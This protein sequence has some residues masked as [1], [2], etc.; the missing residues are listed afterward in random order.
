M[1]SESRRRRRLGGIACFL[2]GI[3]LLAAAAPA[4]WADASYPIWAYAPEPPEPPPP[5]PVPPPNGYLNG[6]CG[7]AVDASGT[8]YLADHYHRV[9]DLL[10]PAHAYAGQISGLEA[11]DGPCGLGLGSGGQLYVNAY[12]RSVREYGPAPGPVLS[13]AGADSAH[14]TG[15]AVDPASGRVYVNDRTYVG[16]YDAA[17][18]PVEEGGQPLRLGVGSLQDGYGL[19]VSAYPG[20][21]GYVYVPDAASNTVKVYDPAAPDKSQPVETIA[22]PPGG[23]SSLRDAAVAV[24]RVSGEVYVVD[25]LQPGATE[26]PHA[27][28]EAFEAG[29]AYAGHLKFEVIDGAPSG[30][31]V[32][33]SAGATQGRV[34]VTSGNTEPGGVY[35]YPPGAVTTALPLPGPIPPPPPAGTSLFTTTAIGGAAEAGEGILCEGDA[36]QVLPPEPVDPTLTTLLEGPGNP[37]IHYHQYK[38]RKA[39]KHRHRKGAR[40]HKRA[41]RALPTAGA[42]SA[43]LGPALIAAS[44]SPAGVSSSSPSASAVGTPG[45]PR[46]A[47]APA[48]PG[49]EAHARADGGEAATFA[50]SHPYALRIG[51][52]LDQG[53]GESDLSNLRLELPPGLLFDPPAAGF[54][55]EAQLAS[56]RSSPFEASASGER[57]PDRS[58]VGTIEVQSGGHEARSFGLFEL[59][60]APGTAAR[61]AAAPFGT[62]L[63]FDAHLGEGEEGGAHLALQAT[64]VPQSLALHSLALNLWGTPW[65]A[66]HNPQRGNC[67]D[68]VE[69]SFGWCKA[70]VG[71][72]VQTDNSPLALLTLPTECGGPLAFTAQAEA[73]GGGAFSGEATNRGA[74]GQPALLERCETLNFEPR[75]NGVFSVRKASSAT[76]FAFRLTNED[77]GLVNPRLRAD[78][79][80]RVAVVH[81]PEGV[82]LNPSLGAGLEVC[83]P[84]QVAA[85]SPT[86]APGSGCPSGSKIGDFSL[87]FPFY[88]GLLDGAIYLAEPYHNPYGSL[89]AV[90][91]VAKSAGRGLLVRASGKLIPDPADGTITATFEH[92]PQLPYT[93]LEVNFRS[94]QRAPLVSPP[95]CGPAVARIELLPWAQGAPTRLEET[96]SPIE[97][98]IEDGPC[99]TAGAPPFAPGAVAGGVNSNIG[100]YTP[101][102][103]HIRRRDTEQEITSYSLVLPKG[104]TGKLAGIPFCPDAAIEAARH[105]SGVA[106]TASPSCPAASQVGRTVTGYGVGSALTYSPGRIYLAGPYHGAPLSL[107]TIDAATIGPFDLGTIVIRS[108]FDL[109][110]RTAQLQIDSRASDPIPHLI[111]GIPLHLRDIRV[112]VDRPEFTH[113]PSSCEPSQLESTLTGSGPPYTNPHEATG[114]ATSHFQLLNCLTLGFHPKLGLRLLG[115]TRRGAYPGLRASFV[116][117]GP[118]DSNLK[119]IA[120]VIPRQMFV[121][122][123]HIR[124]ICTR[125]Q[126]TQERCPADSVYGHAA[127]FTPL[128][129]KPLT[130]NVYLRADPARAL[131]D[132]VADLHSGSIRIIV[133]GGIG[134]A[135]N[136]GVLA[137]FVDL[138]DAPIARFNMTLFGGKRGLFRNSADICRTPPVASLKAL[139]QN[140]IGAIFTSTLRGRCKGKGRGRGK[141]GQ[142]KKHGRRVRS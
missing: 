57:C 95:A 104:I 124:G 86:G 102:F 131:P 25:D 35:A 113:N 13:G 109:D 67:L 4:A 11:L 93:D 140:N 41:R 83:T 132:L 114:T 43:I 119:D 38:H 90:Y 61:L 134:S 44:P 46:T 141:N 70:S 50:G 10:S 52:G 130:G 136:G 69:P 88:N 138:P 42:S 56:P 103:V 29:G 96:E 129:D 64:G 55:T 51:F 105:N 107:V 142:G 63:V 111:D 72:P 58:Q 6:P 71:D 3:C 40:Q 9:V 68:E 27:L 45:A 84:A 16:V 22:G 81:L 94:G 92:L 77:P 18:A 123:E 91:L 99:P 20:T 12:H 121:A 85:E 17:G 30:L 23:F 128:F 115:G 49:L 32:D 47:L 137:Q 117:R 24:D 75:V 39:H 34:Y 28:V 98:G 89:L 19:A 79:Q 33:N 59:E 78:S 126:F 5:N 100:S 133:E 53:S 7:L 135:G 14:P 82:T 74:G 66:S 80:A 120:V 65:D 116:S 73:W 54:C 106:E 125:A 1:I 87:R 15:V 31:A 37:K 110:P 62:P 122:Q 2:V 36:C 127:A 112:Y 76:G 48:S 118:K 60:P 8:I 101:Y 139:G 21:A 26:S 108:A 97:T